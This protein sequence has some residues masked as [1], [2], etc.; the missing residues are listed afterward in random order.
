[1]ENLGAHAQTFRESLGANWLHHEFLDVDVVIGVLATVDDVHHRNRHRVDT[2]GAVQV[3]DVS[4]QR[5]VLVVSGSLGGG[6]GHGEDGVGA[7]AAFVLGTVQLDHDAIEG[8]LVN[9]VF[10]QQRGADRAIDVGHGL[11][12]TFA[13]VTALVAI[14]QLQRFARASG[15]TG[16]RAGAADDAVVEKHVRFDSGIA[17]GVENFTTFDVDDFCHC[18]KHS[19]VDEN[20][21]A[22]GNLFTVGKGC[23]AGRLA[24]DNAH[25]RGHERQIVRYFTGELSVTRFLPSENS[26]PVR[27]KP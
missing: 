5:Q 12:Y 10:T 14:T 7:Q 8:F 26:S 24:D 25:A 1:M 21:A 16:R 27:P 13:Q 18:C 19:K 20:D 11:Q 6:Q 2:R 23:A 15:S 4:V 9:R 3:G 17:T 22:R